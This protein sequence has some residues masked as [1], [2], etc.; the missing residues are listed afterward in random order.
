MQRLDLDRLVRAPGS[1]V[2]ATLRWRHT[3][4]L[5][6]APLDGRAAF[7]Y[8]LV[9]HQS[10]TDPVIEV[11]VRLERPVDQTSFMR[12][13][14]SHDTRIPITRRDAQLERRRV[15]LRARTRRD[16]QGRLGG[17]H[18]LCGRNQN[19]CTRAHRCRH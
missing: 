9:E 8:V 12:G 15:R 16:H 6:Q 5:F 10:R 4:L 19:R 17:S 13:L 14:V 1:F 11:P 18:T 2:D 7:V 3:D